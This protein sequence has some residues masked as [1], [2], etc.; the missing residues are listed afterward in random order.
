MATGV[1]AETLQETSRQSQGIKLAEATANDPSVPR[2]RRRRSPPGRGR[3]HHVAR[4]PH[5]ALGRRRHIDADPDRH[6]R[7]RRARRRLGRGLCALRSAVHERHGLG[8][9]ALPAPPGQRPGHPGQPGRARVGVESGHRGSGPP[10]R[11]HLSRQF[12]DEPGTIYIHREHRRDGV[13]RR[14]RRQHHRPGG[15]GATGRRRPARLHRPTGPSVGRRHECPAARGAPAGADRQDRPPQPAQP[16]RRALP[17]AQ[18]GPRARHHAAHRGGDERTR[19]RPGRPQRVRRRPAV[20]RAH[21]RA[22]QLLER[23]L[24]SRAIA[25]TRSWPTWPI[26]P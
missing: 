14:Q 11:P 15:A 4:I 1:P 3:L 6:R 10:G 24:P 8:S 26:P 25:A 2:R 12:P 18:L 9:G 22:G 13:C 20:R 17:V 7:Q 5:L 19:Q 23:R 21:P 16:R